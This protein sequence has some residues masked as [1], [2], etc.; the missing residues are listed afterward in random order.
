MMKKITILLAA[1]TLSMAANAEASKVVVLK[2]GSAATVVSQSGK[3][4]T[5]VK[6]T[7]KGIDGKAI[8]VQGEAFDGI[9]VAKTADGR[10]VKIVERLVRMDEVTV[11]TGKIQKPVTERVEAAA[12]C[13]SRAL[14]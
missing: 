5:Y 3:T 12:S 13:D 7:D 8:L 10:C 6:S 4:T 1:A 11:E 9:R 2:D 14:W